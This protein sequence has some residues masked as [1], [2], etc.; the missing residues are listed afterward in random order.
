ML[1]LCTTLS[2]NET[3]GLI[4]GSQMAQVIKKLPA[5]AGD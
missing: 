2:P 4:K 5:N 1:T 3:S